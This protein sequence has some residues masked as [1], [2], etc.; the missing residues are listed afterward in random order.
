MAYVEATLGNI[1]LVSGFIIGADLIFQIFF[2]SDLEFKEQ[3]PL[4]HRLLSAS[5]VSF[6]LFVLNLIFDL[7]FLQALVIIYT[8]FVFVFFYLVIYDF[9]NRF[10][11]KFIMRATTNHLLNIFI[12]GYM[13]GTGKTSVWYFFPVAWITYIIYYQILWAVI[14]DY[15]MLYIYNHKQTLKMLTYSAL[16][17]SVLIFVWNTLNVPSFA[18]FLGIG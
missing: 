18:D 6:Y 17:M 2:F 8:P 5:H 12:L 4:A 10:S 7:A 15:K 3:A 11:K 9:P 14:P 1:L 13:F 16:I